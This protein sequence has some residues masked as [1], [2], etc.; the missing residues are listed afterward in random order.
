MK[1]TI[2]SL[3]WETISAYIQTLINAGMPE[4][5]INELKDQLASLQFPLEVDLFLPFKDEPQVIKT[6]LPL[7]YPWNK[8]PLEWFNVQTA[9]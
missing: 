1:S 3:N 6:L 5:T 2:T 7:K 4:N 9:E 8:M